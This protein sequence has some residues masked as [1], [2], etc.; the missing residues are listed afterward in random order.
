MD[1]ETEKIIVME[2]KIYCADY[3]RIFAQFSIL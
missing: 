3:Y 2:Y 1:V